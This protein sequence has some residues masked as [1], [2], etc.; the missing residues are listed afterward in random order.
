MGS[1]TEDSSSPPL[2]SPS[3]SVDVE[4]NGHHG[5]SPRDVTQGKQKAKV[6]YDYDAN[7]SS[8]LSL[9]ADEVY[10]SRNNLYRKVM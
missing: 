6:L 9:L 2:Y 1:I 3:A 5:N 10:L 4:T 7:D 8:E